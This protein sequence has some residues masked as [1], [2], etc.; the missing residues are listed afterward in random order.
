MVEKAARLLFHQGKDIQ[1]NLE[2]L[3]AIRQE[4]IPLFVRDTD[5]ILRIENIAKGVAMPCSSPDSS[6][7]APPLTTLWGNK[8]VN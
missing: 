8:E 3:L 6:I 7:Y 2:E 4:I 1:I 5:R